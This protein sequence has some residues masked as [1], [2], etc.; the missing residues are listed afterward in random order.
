MTQKFLTWLRGLIAAGD[1][2]PF[3][4]TPEWRSLSADVI[5]DDRQECQICRKNGKFAGAVLVHHVMHVKRHPELALSRFYADADGVRRRNLISVC[6]ACHETVCHP[7][8]M[9]R[10]AANRP[11]PVTEERWD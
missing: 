11:T 5:Q 7:E 3:Y 9:R 10:D 8:R 6:R 2:H 1:V 4:V